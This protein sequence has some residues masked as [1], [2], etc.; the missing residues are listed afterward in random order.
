[1]EQAKRSRDSASALQALVGEQEG[2]AYSTFPEVMTHGPR[3]QRCFH[4]KPEDWRRN[5]VKRDFGGK[6]KPVT[7][8]R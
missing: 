6:L 1:M 8:D 2:P 7:G 4:G 3:D 5:K